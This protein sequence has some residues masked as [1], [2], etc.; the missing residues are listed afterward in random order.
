[1]LTGLRYTPSNY[2]SFR[3]FENSIK[4]M[5]RISSGISG[6]LGCNIN[7]KDYTAKAE[8]IEKAGNLKIT[9]SYSSSAS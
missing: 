1:A 6:I 5:V 7:N 9:S 2:F 8:Q 4:R 3:Y